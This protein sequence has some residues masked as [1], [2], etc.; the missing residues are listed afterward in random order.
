MTPTPVTS[1]L[2]FLEYGALGVLVL[3]LFF[4]GA[5]VRSSLNRSQQ[6]IEKVAESALAARDEALQAS[7][8]HNQAIQTLTEKFLQTQ[9]QNL[10]MQEKMTTCIQQIA[11]DTR[12]EHEARHNEHRDMDAKLDKALNGKL[13]DAEARVAALQGK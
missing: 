11:V 4:V 12:R 1:I 10:Q 5:Y 8:E 13:K 3:V 2:P 7:E 9:A 6:F